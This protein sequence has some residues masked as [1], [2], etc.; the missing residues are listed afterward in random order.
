MTR[1]LLTYINLD[2]MG[3]HPDPSAGRAEFVQLWDSLTAQERAAVRWALESESFDDF[4]ERFTSATGIQ[5]R[6]S[7]KHRLT[8]PVL[9]AYYYG[10]LERL[11]TETAKM[12]LVERVLSQGPG[13]E[14]TAAQ[15]DRILTTDKKHLQ[16][17][18]SRLDTDGDGKRAIL[19]EI[20]AYGMQAKLV[21]AAAL[22]EE[23]EQ[24]SAAVYGLADPKVAQAAVQELNKMDH[25]YGDNDKATSSVESQ[26]ERIK[27]LSQAVEKRR[28]HAE[29]ALKA[30]RPQV[31]PPPALDMRMDR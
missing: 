29:R 8:R 6:T 11:P 9:K 18:A 3:I 5:S 22:D 17:L 27:R 2:D 28:G 14:L 31:P 7:A 24:V 10:S 25:E 16:Q 15:A 4:A 26:A 19:R 21:E 12:L 1:S 30:K 23:G 20:I 13:T